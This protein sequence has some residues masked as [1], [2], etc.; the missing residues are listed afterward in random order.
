MFVTAPVLVPELHRLIVGSARSRQDKEEQGLAGQKAPDSPRGEA[1]TE[2][3]QFQQR[4]NLVLKLVD[5]VGNPLTAVDGA[6][7]LLFQ[8]WQ[9][10][11]A[12]AEADNL[13]NEEIAECFRI[14]REQTG[15]MESLLR[16]VRRFGMLTE[17]RTPLS[18]TNEIIHTLVALV[19]MEHHEQGVELRKHLDP[20]IPAVALEQSLV[21]FCIYSALGL[22]VENCA[23]GGRLLLTTTRGDG[24]VGVGLECQMVDAG[25]CQQAA[26]AGTGN[27]SDGLQ[28]LALACEEIRAALEARGGQLAVYCLPMKRCG[29]NLF[30]P[31][32]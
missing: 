28:P 2:Q 24:G 20:A 1:A 4:V 32:N 16:G 21:V 15:R 27:G 31:A 14:L 6:I 13:P 7:D 26:C 9:K 8:C 12:R 25:R 22:L 23:R 3:R 19:E 11:L 5:E 18:D 17:S 29:I 30:F 10:Q